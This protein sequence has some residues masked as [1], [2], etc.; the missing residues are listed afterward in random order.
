MV[1]TGYSEV[2]IGP[3]SAM[4]LELER[5][6]ADELAEGAEIWDETQGPDNAPRID[7][8]RDVHVAFLEWGFIFGTL[9]VIAEQKCISVKKMEIVWVKGF[10]D[11]AHI[12]TTHNA[13]CAVPN[14]Y[15]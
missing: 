1:E 10:A 15:L 8:F 2:C 6:R 9:T 4:I 5:R 7:I 12:Y 11:L 13:R 14:A 3:K